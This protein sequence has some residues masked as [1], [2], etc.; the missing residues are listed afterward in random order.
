MPHKFGQITG[1]ETEM[2][3]LTLETEPEKKEDKR[4][5]S[6]TSPF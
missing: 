4:K 6:L 2:P 5:K 3:V 1:K